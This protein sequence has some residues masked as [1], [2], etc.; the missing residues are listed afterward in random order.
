MTARSEDQVEA[1]AARLREQGASAIGVPAD[2]ADPEQVEEVVESALDQFNRVDILVNNAG[3]IWPLEEV[4]DM[5]GDEWSY[6]IQV[7]LL[8]PFY[9]TQSVLPVM[10][11]QQFGRIINISSGA[12]MNP[13]AGESAY[14]VSKAGLDMLTK[15]LGLELAG[16]GRHRQCAV[17]RLD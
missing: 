4:A 1:V 13:T 3:I 14:C 5:D 15:V 8:G 12:A 17:S 9:L 7:N 11:D 16:T 6:N 10:I 2:V